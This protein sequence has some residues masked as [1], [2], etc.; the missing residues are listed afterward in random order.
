MRRDAVA[1]QRVV[2]PGRAC[3][4]E[5]RARRQVQR[6]VDRDAARLER[7]Q[8]GQHLVQAE[9][10]QVVE[11]GVAEQRQEQPGADDFA[12][13]EQQPAETFD[14][15]QAAAAQVDHRLQVQRE[16]AGE[17]PLAQRACALLRDHRR[18][19]R[20]ARPQLFPALLHAARELA[21]RRRFEL[22]RVGAE[23][24]EHRDRVAGGVA[25]RHAQARAYA[26]RLGAPAPCRVARV[27]RVGRR[28]ADLAAA[29]GLRG[30]PLA[31]RRM[32]VDDGFAVRSL[33]RVGEAFAHRTGV[34]L[35]GERAV[36]RQP[37]Q[38]DA[39]HPGQRAELRQLLGDDVGP[40]RAVRG[41]RVGQQIGVLRQH[42]LVRAELGAQLQLQARVDHRAHPVAVAR[43]HRRAD[44]L[45]VEQRAEAVDFL[46]QHAGADA[47][48][49][50]RA[51]DAQRG[52][53]DAAGRRRGGQHLG[54]ARALRIAQP[55]A[56]VVAQGRENGLACALRAVRR[57]RAGI[58][59]D[60]EER[61]EVFVGHGVEQLAMAFDQLGGARAE[62]VERDVGLADPLLPTAARVPPARA[63]DLVPL[64][65]VHRDVGLAQQRVG[66]VGVERVQRDASAHADAQRP[67]RDRVEALVDRVVH[68]GQQRV[69]FVGRAALLEVG[70]DDDE[71]VA[72]QPG[73]EIDFA[74]QRAQPCGKFAQQPVADRVAVAVV[75]RLE[76][77]EVEHAQRDH[78]V[79][80]RGTRQL[81]VQAPGQRVAVGQL[82]Q[83]VVVGAVH[84]L[85][86]AGL[87]RVDVLIGADRAQRAAVGIALD[88]AADAAYPA[89]ASV[90]GA[91]AQFAVEV[92]RAAAQRSHRGLQRARQVVAVHA[93]EQLGAVDPWRLRRQA[94]HQ[95]PAVVEVHPVGS[96]IE[97]PHR[98]LRRV[99]REL[100]PRVQL[101]QFALGG[102]DFGN[103]ENDADQ[104]AD[105][106]VGAR[107]RRLV[108][109]HRSART[110]GQLDFG[111]VGLRARVGQQLGVGRGV[112]LREFGP[113]Q[114]EHGAP[115]QRGD[116]FAGQLLER[117]VG[118]EVAAVA[119]L[120]EH[121]AGN[122]VD[123][124]AHEAQ[125]LVAGIVDRRVRADPPVAWRRRRAFER[126]LRCGGEAHRRRLA[127]SSS[128][129][130]RYFTPA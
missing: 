3:G 122:R 99:D 70:D 43:E 40:Q 117:A 61:R 62:G 50:V 86:L 21:H 31:A 24:A 118:A 18:R 36:R 41:Q 74:H 37:H 11:L 114:V 106:A 19:R 102:L 121:R 1:A 65:G 52:V 69:E 66:V 67:R 20:A 105:R 15:Q 115:D 63:V 79:E 80:P 77:V 2:D 23:E 112:A 8:R 13:V 94:Q 96:D 25:Y 56:L 35:D 4:V 113:V 49:R 98:Q 84:D 107:E 83:V 44:Q 5:Q 57:R 116:R 27:E 32:R 9:A 119:V 17:Q 125:R 42:Q 75:D 100:E 124:L 103:V 58:S 123:Q 6:H 76:V 101:V 104:S 72:A 120:V 68:P 30:Q 60:V 16:A 110:V 97:L 78:G 10:E 73:Q 14:L 87:A 38:R 126:I 93:G 54:Q 91:H 33:Q 130:V 88:D 46:D 89:P 111:L 45:L 48:Q 53:G 85:L 82:G 71:F 26:Q 127:A 108:E 129:A 59:G 55:L 109:H 64:G 95:R 39:A 29:P 47:D 90:G 28:G 51:A 92:G 12:V 81:L 128:A 7:D 34:A 22:V